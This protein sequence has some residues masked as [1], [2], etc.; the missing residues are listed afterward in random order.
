MRLRAQT[1]KI[2]D[3]GAGREYKHLR[4][5]G[6][7]E[8]VDRRKIKDSRRATS[9]YNRESLPVFNRRL[10]LVKPDEWEGERRN[11]ALM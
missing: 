4:S 10:N 5:G 8:Q 6:G 2:Q 9:R 11:V 1:N 7:H 3:K